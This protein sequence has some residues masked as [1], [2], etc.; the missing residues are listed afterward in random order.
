[1]KEGTTKSMSNVAMA[2]VRVASNIKSNYG[3]G[4][5][6]SGCFPT[7][8]SGCIDGERQS[9][10]GGGFGV[11]ANISLPF[12]S[13]PAIATTFKGGGEEEQRCV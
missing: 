10:G 1:M 13:S 11:V 12:P 8:R 6:T 7:K 5:S 2:V 9:C 3:H 4:S